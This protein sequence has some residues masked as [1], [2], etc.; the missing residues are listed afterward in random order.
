M[1]GNEIL[2][3]IREAV[4][5]AKQKGLHQVTIESLE[6]L[7]SILEKGQVTGR[8]PSEVDLTSTLAEYN[9]SRAIELETMKLVGM[10]G[11]NALKSL[12]LIN[13]GAAV[14]LL[15]FLSHIWDKTP[16]AGSIRGLTEALLFF[17]AGV[18]LSSIASGTTYLTGIFQQLEWLKIGNGIH[19]LTIILVIA[20]YVVFGFGGYE[21]YVA[22]RMHLGK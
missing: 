13:G 16:V 15:A 6:G 9:A 4:H 18:L 14:A 20:A 21:A 2:G 3:S 8:K 5:D 10:A 17:V 22:I 7:L 19:Y 1:E 11:Q 12:M